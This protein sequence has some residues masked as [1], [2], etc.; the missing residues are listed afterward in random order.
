MDAWLQTLDPDPHTQF[1][2]WFAEATTA[3]VRAPEAMTLATAAPD[4]TPSAR[5]VLL[6]GRGPDGYVFFT[7]HESRKGHELAVNPRAALVLYWQPLD[8]Q[9]R[10]EGTVERLG[11]DA[12]YAY[13]ASRPRGSRI[14]AWSS[15]QSRSVAGRDELE[16]RYA[17]T[18]ARHP[19][20]DVPLPPFW[21]GY[22]V[23]PSAMEFW[24][25]RDNRFH[26][27]V[28]YE[29]T[30]QGWQRQRLGP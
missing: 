29:R 7:N 16:R 22:R 10:I 20:D 1:A 6:K 18:D 23:V 13:F 4:G 5:M 9:V 15:P 25:G 11:D 27:R 19:G 8:R 28:R 24:Q 14:G 3:G 26:D 17:E 12:S 30:G 2:R 21:G